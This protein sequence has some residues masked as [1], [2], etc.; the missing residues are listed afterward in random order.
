[1][2][3]KT[4]ILRIS[5]G[6]AEEKSRRDG[7]SRHRNLSLWQSKLIAA[8][9]LLIALAGGTQA[10]NPE[11]H[12]KTTF[13][14][15]VGRLIVQ[16]DMPL[17]LYVSTSPDETPRRL[18]RNDEKGKEK[19]PLYLDGPGIHF[20]RHQDNIN[21]RAEM[22]P[23]WADGQAPRTTLSFS[24]APTY[25]SG[26]MTY[27]G[28]NLAAKLS[29]TDDLSGVH[30]IYY[31][32]G[33]G[34]FEPYRQIDAGKEGKYQLSYY[35]VDNVGNVETVKH[36][37]FTVDLTAPA[38]VHR[39]AGTM[40]D[41]VI[42]AN[43][44]ITLTSA[45]ELSGVERTVYRF[46]N[47]PEKTYRQGTTISVSNLTD[48]QHTLYYYSEDRVRNRETEKSAGFF[49]DKTPPIMSADVLGDKFIVG[50]KVYF[51]G[52]TKL[53]LTA[54]DNK[55]GVSEIRYS[56]NGE[57]FVAYEDPFYLP[58]KTGKH[59]IRYYS[60]DEMGNTSIG[61]YSHNT[62]IVYVDLT[63]PALS[64]ELSGASF[65]KGDVMYISPE[66]KITLKG[67]D[68]ESGLQYLS[69]SVDGVTDEIRYDAPFSIRETG[70]HTIRYF[71]YDN[72]NNRNAREFD[73][74][75]DAEG[76]E[77]FNTFSVKH[78]DAEGAD[79]EM[80]PSYVM[81]YLAATDLMTGN[82]EI[83]Y[84]VNGGNEL[85][86]TAPIKGFAK[87]TSYVVKVRAK[88]KLGNFSAKTVEFKTGEY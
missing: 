42:A 22:Y 23:I 57:P 10:Q 73:I 50:D 14:D 82:A 49:L 51:S 4:F 52:R 1:M 28:K 8:A 36:K 21:H 33:G 74:T 40:K 68:T 25:N 27:F 86:Y 83:Y 64:H 61:D 70:A 47:E 48:G 35:A 18:D 69:Y 9:S 15:S 63:G 7:I 56:I 34:N 58:S 3:L 32:T 88:D 44:Q 87:N 76:P 31:S 45:D 13:T 67:V 19:E 30:Q 12:Q 78:I 38:T 59:Q 65:R 26:G 43:V 39:I 66:T 60:V 54:V 55:S 37:D 16:V 85:P 41:D 77:I 84:S 81:L 20:I 11:E 24:D 29:A 62:G 72:V 53:K 17:Y 75:V 71:G 6:R 5:D 46:D 2:I 79:T 80:Y